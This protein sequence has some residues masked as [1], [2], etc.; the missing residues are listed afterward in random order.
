MIGPELCSDLRHLEEPLSCS[1]PATPCPRCTTQTSGVLFFEEPSTMSET[2]TSAVD[3]RERRL[4]KE[5]TPPIHTNSPQQHT[6][7]CRPALLFLQGLCDRPPGCSSTIRTVQN[8]TINAATSPLSRRQSSKCEIHTAGTGD[9][10]MI[11]TTS[12][13][14]LFQVTI[15]RFA[16]AS[17]GVHLRWSG[18]R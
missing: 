6:V 7:A 3:S 2:A 14:S 18:P 4:S 9:R 17:S 16:V 12:R 8:I 10:P 11:G 15:P 13:P 5:Q 1:L